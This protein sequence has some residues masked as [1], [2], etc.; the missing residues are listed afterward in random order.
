MPNAEQERLTESQAE[1]VLWMKWG[2]YRSERQWG[3]HGKSS[4][5]GMTSRMDS[6]LDRSYQRHSI[7]RVP[8]CVP[9]MPVGPS[10]YLRLIYA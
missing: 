7:N 4:L 8:N 9:S 2:P 6:Q 10:F 5:D 3:A 1:K